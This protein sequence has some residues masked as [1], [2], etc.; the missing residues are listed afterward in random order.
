M[1]TQERPL[2][3]LG[4]QVA[5]VH[6]SNPSVW[7][8]SRVAEVDDNLVWVETPEL[9]VEPAWPVE[10]DELF[11]RVA[12]PGD[13]VYTVHARAVVVKTDPERL[14]GL[15][16]I[17]SSRTQQ[18]EYFRVPV[19]ITTDEAT[20][21]T[22]GG[23]R[24]PATLHLRD[25]SATGVRAH[26]DAPVSIGDQIRMRLTLTGQPQPIE[27][28]ATVVRSNERPGP[29]GTY[30]EIGAAFMS[31]APSIRERIVHFALSMQLEQRRRGKL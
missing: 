10:G 6:R 7:Y 29:A 21:T 3:A 30:W 19:S 17:G 12:R 1:I 5:L 23:S 22:L 25:L 14:V 24:F 31:L 9:N 13:P 20:F 27:L 16:I 26:C 4:Q 18:R 11:L 15:R 8:P 2:L 28:M